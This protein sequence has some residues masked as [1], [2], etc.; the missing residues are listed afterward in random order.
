MS[1]APRRLR[2]CDS[3]MDK[4][5][6]TPSA[7]QP[8]PDDTENDDTGIDDEFVAGLDDDDEIVNLEVND[9]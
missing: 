6:V 5:N 7:D 9:G 8:V 1:L 3:R 4:N 2:E